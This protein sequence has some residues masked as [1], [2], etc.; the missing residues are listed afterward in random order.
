MHNAC[1]TCKHASRAISAHL[2]QSRRASA[3]CAWGPA[4]SGPLQW[5]AGQQGRGEVPQKS[6]ACAPPAPVEFYL[7]CNTAAQAGREPN[8]RP[9]GTALVAPSNRTP[10][11]PFNKHTPLC[12]PPPPAQGLNV[13]LPVAHCASQ[14]LRGVDACSP[15]A[16]GGGGV[17]GWWGGAGWALCACQQAMPDTKGS[18]S[19]ET[20]A[21]AQRDK[22]S[23]QQ[24]ARAR[25]QSRAG[26][27]PPLPRPSC[28]AR[29]VMKKHSQMKEYPAVQQCSTASVRWHTSVTAQQFRGVLWLR[30]IK[31]GT[32][33]GRRRQHHGRPASSRRGSS[34]ACRRQ[35]HGRLSC[36]L[37]SWGGPS[38]ANHALTSSDSALRRVSSALCSRRAEGSHA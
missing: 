7:P 20:A 31:Q 2:S 11:S 37:P 3:S 25:R 15:K 35:M 34:R 26:G 5:V 8:L 19:A 1:P 30:D 10:L 33:R 23:Q 6:S 32:S 4:A 16:A 22:A 27:G 14:I 28:R 18:E 9:P 36:C 29:A 17:V 13:L 24:A 38:A 21:A 12:S